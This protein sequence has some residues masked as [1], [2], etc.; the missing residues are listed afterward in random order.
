MESEIKSLPSELR[1]VFQ[2]IFTAILKDL[3]FGHPDADL[4]RTLRNPL[5]NFGGGFLQATTP[6]TPND[7]FSIPHSFGRAPYLLWPVL[8][9]DTVN[10]AIV[11]LTVTRAAD[12]KRIYL[13]S[14]VAG[15][16][17]IVAVEG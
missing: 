7:A 15:A 3:R 1:P 17:V 6:T 16:N 11:P 10:A 9:L 13:A 8:P 4:M 12:E 5:E 2:R 14:S